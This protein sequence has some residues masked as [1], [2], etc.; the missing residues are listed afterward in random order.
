MAHLCTHISFPNTTK[1][2]SQNSKQVLLVFPQNIDYGNKST[3]TFTKKKKQ[4]T[5]CMRWD[6]RVCEPSK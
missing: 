3:M 5:I 6:L 4:I 1:A 2:I